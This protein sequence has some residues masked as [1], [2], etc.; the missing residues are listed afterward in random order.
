M[1]TSREHPITIF[2]PP[3]TA[4]FAPILDRRSTVRPTRRTCRSWNGPSTRW[5]P[6]WRALGPCRSFAFSSAPGDAWGSRRLGP[7][8][9]TFTRSSRGS[10]RSSRFPDACRRRY[11]SW[12]S[13]KIPIPRRY[14]PSSRGGWTR[15]P[16]SCTSRRERR[17]CDSATRFA[18]C[19]TGLVPRTAR[20]VEPGR[21]AAGRAW[22]ASF[23]RS[24]RSERAA[25]R[26][27][28][29]PVDP[30][31]REPLRREQRRRVFAGRQADPPVPSNTDQYYN[32]ARVL[33]AGLG[34]VLADGY[35][36]G[37][38]ADNTAQLLDQPAYRIEAE[39]RSRI[40][41]LENGRERAAVILEEVPEVGYQHLLL[42]DPPRHLGELFMV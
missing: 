27:P 20:V 21:D 42:R 18:G 1:V 4:V 39:R 5:S 36:E 8:Y 24:C 23:E 19:C 37:E 12:A 40:A 22:P 13:S 3:G 33:D 34:L 6:R 9:S 17:W 38:V 41:P 26:D 35:T 29:S 14:R 16:T 15:G 11:T 32:S 10:A 2:D 30:R 31:V 25:T 28:P 7:R